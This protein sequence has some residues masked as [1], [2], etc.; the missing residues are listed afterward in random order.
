MSLLK[1]F[2]ELING[3]QTTVDISQNTI[4]TESVVVGGDGGTELTKT[5]LDDLIAG[6]ASTSQVVDTFT[7]SGT[8]ITNKFVTLSETPSLPGHTILLIDGSPST[9][10][11]TDFTV[12]GTQLSWSGLSLDGIL[13]S[14]D[15][16][17]VTYGN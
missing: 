8:D 3:D 13:S 1:F 4:V 10:Y 5:I 6:G 9:F 7:L 12:S 17:T 14:G 16:L 11:G 15:N 2:S